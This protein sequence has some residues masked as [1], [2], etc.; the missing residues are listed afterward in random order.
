MKNISDNIFW[1][2]LLIAVQFLRLEWS[3]NENYLFTWELKMISQISY[4]DKY[5]S[6]AIIL[7]IS[8]V[9]IIFQVFSPRR[10]YVLIPIVLFL[11]GYFTLIYLLGGWFNVVTFFESSIPAS[12][13]M[14]LLILKLAGL[15]SVFNPKD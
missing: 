14:V 2:I 8:Q 10:R 5:C 15:S 7:L 9:W 13:A 12:I 1:L 3:I 6:T 4:I 11:I